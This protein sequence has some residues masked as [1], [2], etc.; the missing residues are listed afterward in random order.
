MCL[1][2]NIE[3]ANLYKWNIA[4]YFGGMKLLEVIIVCFDPGGPCSK[5]TPFPL[6]RGSSISAISGSFSA[7]SSRRSKSLFRAPPVVA[8]TWRPL[9]MIIWD[10]R[11]IGECYMLASVKS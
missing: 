4:T 9:N 3:S 11:Y 6:L 10:K 1:K 2:T 7:R 8:A 5:K